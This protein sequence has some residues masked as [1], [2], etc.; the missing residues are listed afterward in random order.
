MR[1]EVV[2]PQ[3][4][5]AVS[6]LIL[7]RWL[8]RAGDA[9][10]SGDVLF[11]IDSDKAIVEVEAFA[12]GTLT[13]IMHGDNASVMPLQVVAYIETEE[14]S[15]A[16]ELPAAPTP[17]IA[18]TDNGAKASPLA[19]R[20]AADLGIDLARVC[21]TGPGGRITVDDVRQHNASRQRVTPTTAITR[22]LASPKARMLAR[23][24][25]IDLAQMPGSGVN[26]MVI[27]RDLEHQ[28]AAAPQPIAQTNIVPPADAPA[29]SRRVIAQRMTASKQQVPHFYLMADVNMTQAA[30]LREYC[31]NVLKWE[32]AP[33]YTDILVRACALALRAIPEV[34]RS[35]HEDGIVSHETINIGVA[36]SLDDGLL[37]PTLERVDTLSLREVSA[38]V[39]DIAARAREKRLRPSELASKSLTVSNLGMYR[40][41]TFIAIIDMPDP[42]I[43]A[44]G[45]VSDRAIVVDKQVVVQPMCTLTLSVDH[46]ILDGAVAARYLE[47]VIQIVEAPF[48]ILGTP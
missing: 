13:D 9:V 31:R 23:E 3:I 48:A 37:V 6:E 40:V 19:E 1:V 2:V 4:G 22:P 7:T 14:V 17:Q 43:L 21:G 5:E 20:M 28:P 27:A 15:P 26:G 25:G 18:P 46:R 44:V 10:K 36:V 42:M 38:G 32:K 29:R 33:T 41:D 35:F 8:K 12:D 45:R 47:Q 24:R 30:A 39:R 34:N 11:E 16:P